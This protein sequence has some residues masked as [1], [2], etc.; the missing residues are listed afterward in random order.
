M[1]TVYFVRHAQPNYEN[2]NDETRELTKKGL[3]DRTLVTGFLLGKGVDVVLSSPYK[4]SV[5]TVKDFADHYGF[6]IKTI[7]GFR[8]RKIDSVWIE[9][10]A[11]F[12][13]A[14]WADFDYKLTDGESLHEVQTRNIKALEEVLREYENKTVVIGSHGTALS[15]VIHYYDNSFGYDAFQKVK[16]IMPWVVKFRFDERRFVSFE[17]IDL[18][19]NQKSLLI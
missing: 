11:A 16:G 12:S 8:E 17:E 4:R 15:T 9:D 7:A 5:D 2:R 18:A 10:F 3:K 14:Q 13:K 1:T 6:E 19:K